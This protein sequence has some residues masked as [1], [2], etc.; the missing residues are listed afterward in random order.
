MRHTP[1]V[2]RTITE[3]RRRLLSGTSLDRL[4]GLGPAR[5]AVALVT[6]AALATLF[7]GFGG[8]YDDFA[9]RAAANRDQTATQRML[10]AAI[11][12]DMSRGFVLAARDLVPAGATF[13]V[14]TGDKVVVS[15]PVSI[16]AVR[17]YSQ[18]QLLP[19]R[20][21]SSAEAQ[22]L[23]CYGCDQTAFASRFE[24]VWDA[25]PGLAI[26]KAHA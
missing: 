5:C 15:T 7:V 17:G 26:M 8:A 25:E 1:A 16:Y 3:G 13:A 20:L 23:L 18:F 9:G 6:A 4:A 10:S 11:A 19:R 22:W 2:Q 12:T 21:V 14:E 24:V